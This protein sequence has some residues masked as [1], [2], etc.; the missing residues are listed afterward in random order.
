MIFIGFIRDSVSPWLAN[1]SRATGVEA[2]TQK[3]LFYWCFSVTPCLRGEI[4]L[5]QADTHDLQLRIRL[6][7]VGGDMLEGQPEGLTLAGR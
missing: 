2:Q 4:A 6:V 7:P 1:F 3:K 5:L